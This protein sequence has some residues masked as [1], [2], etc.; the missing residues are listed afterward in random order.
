MGSNAFP[1]A[2]VLIGG[3]LILALA[4]GWAQF[5]AMQATRRRD[6]ETPPDDPS[7]GMKSGR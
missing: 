7:R 1:W 2:F 6:P 5:R 4:I 3:P